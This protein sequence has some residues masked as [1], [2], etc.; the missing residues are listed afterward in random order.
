VKPPILSTADIEARANGL[1]EEYARRTRRPIALP[2]PIERIIEQ[3]LD[4]PIHWKP[5]PGRSARVD[6]SKIT[7]PSFGEP[8]R[9]LMNEDCCGTLFHDHPG[10]IETAMAHEAGH[11]V[12]HIDHG[13]TAQLR[14]PLTGEAGF[15]SQAGD[16]TDLLDEILAWRGPVDDEWWREWQA[17][18]FMRF[19]LMP[20]T[21][22]AP[23]LEEHGFRTWDQLY[24][25]RRRCG[26]TISALVVHLSK[27]DLIRVDERRVI[28]VVSM[29]SEN[30][31]LALHQA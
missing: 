3:V 9:I 28:H 22:L 31:Q 29:Q 17:H 25:L 18:T 23:A 19:A 4:I 30:R 12:F 7:H 11:G 20:R 10:L 5:L 16:F 21:L 26:V 13:Q 2:V 27:L 15:A 1:L 8:C 24:N 14:L 6:V